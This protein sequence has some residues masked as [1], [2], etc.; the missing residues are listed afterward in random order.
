MLGM[1]SSPRWQA[2]RLDGGMPARGLRVGRRP[3]MLIMAAAYEGKPLDYDEL[4]RWSRV[5]YE[6]GTAMRRGER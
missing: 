4:E 5:G 3:G 2:S 6:R 1:T